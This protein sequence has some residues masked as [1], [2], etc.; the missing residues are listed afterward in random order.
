[1][2][3]LQEPTQDLRSTNVLVYGFPNF[4]YKNDIYTIVSGNSILTFFLC[5]LFFKFY[6]WVVRVSQRTLRLIS[7]S[8]YAP[9]ST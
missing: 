7:G 4:W 9:L 5:F 8:M 3:M 1:M 6:N 2:G